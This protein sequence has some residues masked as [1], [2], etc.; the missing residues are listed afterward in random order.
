[1]NKEKLEII[2]LNIE[3]FKHN[4][5]IN[6]RT[7][8]EL[9]VRDIILILAAYESQMITALLEEELKD[10]KEVKALKDNK[11]RE[12][13]KKIEKNWEEAAYE[14]HQTYEEEA[15]LVEFH[16]ELDELLKDL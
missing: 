9:S 11:I 10:P 13:V 12:V 14:I 7:E 3:E 5:M 8:K 4:L 1:M 6:A 15:E 2:R 16:K